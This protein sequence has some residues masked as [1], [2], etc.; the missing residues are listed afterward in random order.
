MKHP[1]DKPESYLLYQS[2]CLN[3]VIAKYI[4]I[5]ESGWECTFWQYG[6]VLS[7]VYFPVVGTKVVGFKHANVAFSY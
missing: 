3:D 1:V 4:L 2:K 6:W 7:N 5:K